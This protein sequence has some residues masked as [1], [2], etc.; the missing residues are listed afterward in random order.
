M[1][2]IEYL[3][4]FFDGEGYITFSSRSGGKSTRYLV[5]GVSN[6]NKNVIDA[7]QESFGGSSH[8]MHKP[9][10]E[11]GHRGSWQWKCCSNVAYDLLIQMLPYLIVKKEEAEIAIEFQQRRRANKNLGMSRSLSDIDREIDNQLWL[12]LKEAK[13][14]EHTAI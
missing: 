8:V 11:R 13:K 5:I 12:K 1:L 7:V 4:G 9:K 10:P 3:A 2:S 14:K 6:C